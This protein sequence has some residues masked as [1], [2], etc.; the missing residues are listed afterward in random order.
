MAHNALADFIQTICLV[1]KLY[2]ILDQCTI[3]ALG[4]S[5]VASPFAKREVLFAQLSTLGTLDTYLHA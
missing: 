2:S 4:H 1:G 3:S 5:I